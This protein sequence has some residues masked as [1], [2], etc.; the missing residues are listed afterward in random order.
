MIDVQVYIHTETERVADL[1]RRVRDAMDQPPVGWNCPARIDDKYMSESLS[2]RKARAIALKLSKM[3]TDL[4]EG[5]LFAG[6]MTLENPRIHAEWGFPD[7]TT[8]AE[9][10]KGRKH[11]VSI[12]SVFGHIVPDSPRLLKQGL[13]GNLTDVEA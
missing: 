12:H 8:E 1:R 4:W 10:E 2:V 3:P 13:K 7:Y 5:Q 11:G 6:S 9:R